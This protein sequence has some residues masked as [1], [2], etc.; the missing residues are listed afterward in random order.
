MAEKEKEKQEYTIMPW[1]FYVLTLGFCIVMTLCVTFL[2]HYFN[3][4]ALM[5]F[6][7]VPLLIYTGI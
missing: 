5:F 2:A 6:Y 1:Y 3:R 4:W 7:A